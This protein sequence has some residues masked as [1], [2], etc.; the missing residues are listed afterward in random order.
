M[1]RISAKLR[2]LAMDCGPCRSGFCCGGCLCCLPEA[3][4]RDIVQEVRV[5]NDPDWLSYRYE[6][7]SCGER[8]DS[9][10]PC[11]SCGG[12]MRKRANVEARRGVSTG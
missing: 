2:N 8:S 9:D 6:C 7:E 12:V 4:V 11:P 5:D 3:A 10:E 1:T